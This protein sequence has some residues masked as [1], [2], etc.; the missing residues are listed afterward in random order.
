MTTTPVLSISD[1]LLA[2]LQQKSKAATPGPWHLNGRKSVRGSAKEYIARTNWLNG[3][4]NASHIAATNPATILALVEH[5]RSLTERLE[6]AG[7]WISV[8]VRL[9]ERGFWLVS[10][11]TDDGPE[12]HVLQLNG[13]G[14]W[15][16]EGEPTFCQGCYFRPTH[17]KPRPLPAIAQEGAD[18]E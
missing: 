15:I 5:I 2:D 6:K 12:T 10:V 16:Y 1:D 13:K 18:H 8:E 7:E 3:E 4:H 17:W 14:Q 11:D 9:P